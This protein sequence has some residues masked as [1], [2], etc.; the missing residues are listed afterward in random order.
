MTSSDLGAL[1]ASAQAHE[2]AAR[3]DEAL[4]ELGTVIERARQESL[5]SFEASAQLHR[6]RV[7]RIKS[8][9]S[10]AEESIRRGADL[11]RR[12]GDSV[13]EAQC[14]MVLGE[15]YSDQGRFRD[16]ERTCR[17]AIILG[18]QAASQVIQARA[19][20]LLGTAEVLQGKTAE[21][22]EHIE[23]GVAVYQRLGD[24]RGTATSLLMLGRLDHMIGQLGAA[25]RTIERAMLIFEELGETRATVAAAFSLGQMDLERWVLDDA[26]RFATRGLALTQGTGDVAMELRCRVLQAQ[27]DIEDGHSAAAVDALQ[28]A[29]VLCSRHEL[30]SILPEIHR[31]M[32]Q[33]RLLAGQALEAETS[34]R[35]G[36]ASATEDDSYS[37]GTCL[38]VLASALD[39]RNLVLDA[40]QNFIHAIEHLEKASETY[41]LGWGHL[42][43]GQ[44]LI[45]HGRRDDARPHL[46]Q[47]ATA[48]RSLENSEKLALIERLLA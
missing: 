37:T 45:T 23:Q 9:L 42:S 25:A 10:A 5:P 6:A 2:P 18:G 15:I 17:E 29:L 33:A 28:E 7:L 30:A 34:A 48:F 12:L 20:T 4:L 47:A 3:Y 24:Q 36:L 21:A 13:G 11:Y 40:E 26:R 46:E 41:E 19:V 35:A 27:I 31:T 8:E 44:F 43:F 39:A 22:R 16:L 38:L 14:L 1:L 32:A